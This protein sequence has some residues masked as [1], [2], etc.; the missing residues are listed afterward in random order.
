LT[1]SLF[2]GGSAARDQADKKTTLRIAARV[3]KTFRRLNNSF[4]LRFIFVIFFQKKL[5]FIENGTIFLGGVY[6]FL[7]VGP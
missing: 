7:L 6:I 3:K 4:L 2:G 1:V 5:K